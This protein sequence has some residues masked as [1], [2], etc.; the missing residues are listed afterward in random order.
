MATK[1]WFY[2]LVEVPL[3]AKV[4]RVKIGR[5]Y[6]K[7]I[8]FLL[9][10]EL[11]EKV[12]NHSAGIHSRTYKLCNHILTSEWVL[13]DNPIL[14]NRNYNSYNDGN[15][16]RLIYNDLYKFTLNP[17]YENWLLAQ[18]KSKPKLVSNHLM[19]KMIESGDIYCKWDSNNRCHT[20]M[21]VLKSDIRNRFIQTLEGESLTSIDIKAS[22]PTLLGVIM[23]V[24]D[25]YDEWRKLC[26]DGTI[27]SSIPDVSREKGKN[28]IFASLFG[29]NR[30]GYYNIEFRE[31]W[32]IVY[33]YIVQYKEKKGSH[34]SLANDLQKLESHLIYDY[35]CTEMKKQYPDVPIFT[36]HDQIY[37]PES[38]LET[39]SSIFNKQ[40]E[41]FMES[42][43]VQY[44][45]QL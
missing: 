1:H 16:K 20:N 17:E 19:C 29:Q 35:I 33:D 42:D 41:K 44:I 4:L 11:I 36:V 30:M 38:S 12:K 23:P 22:Q 32:P 8:N 39:H 27:Y 13:W 15:I 9:R 10:N 3:N 18:M 34:S 7:H 5:H 24:G 31:R 26:E 43:I 28:L 40:I 2:D 45:E 21:T 37:F 6:N 25:E 14:I